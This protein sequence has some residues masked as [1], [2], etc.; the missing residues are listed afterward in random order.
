VKGSPVTSGDMTSAVISQARW[1]SLVNSTDLVDYVALDLN[2]MPGVPFEQV[3][4]VALHCRDVLEELNLPHGLKTS[5]CSRL[6]IYI[7]MM[8]KTTYESGRLFCENGGNAGRPI[9][10][11]NWRGDA[12]RG[13]AR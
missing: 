3:M 7:P 13:P 12:H 8:P 1:F 11:Q 2:P 4:Q 5:G 10:F 9:G 6:H